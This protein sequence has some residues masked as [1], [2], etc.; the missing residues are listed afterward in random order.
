MQVP[1]TNNTKNIQHVGNKT[2]MPGQTREVEESHIHAHFGKPA[3][4][5]PQ[6]E[7]ENILDTLLAG[8]VESVVA[9]LDALSSDDLDAVEKMEQDAKKPRRGVLNAI[10]E[11][12][13]KRAAEEK[14]KQQTEMEQFIASLDGMSDEEMLELVELYKEDDENVAYLDALNAEIEKRATADG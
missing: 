7:T 6:K 14:D 1:Y 12:R 13:L 11:L 8:K 9:G 3:E 10:A 5:A 4:S 2:I